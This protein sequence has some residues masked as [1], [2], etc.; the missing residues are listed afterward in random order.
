MDGDVAPLR[1]L[2]EIKE[3]YRAWMMVDEAHA[4]GLYGARRRGLLEEAGVSD[5]VEVQMGTLGKALGSAGGY[6]A[7]SRL[8]VDYLVN[9]AR[10][11]IFS[12]APAPAAAT[13]ATA[14]IGL[15]QSP[16]G[17]D[18]CVR[19]WSNV[20]AARKMMDS[21]IGANTAGPR[22]RSAIL[23]LILGDERR[24]MTAA[25]QLR[26]LGLFVPAIRYPTVARG[27]ARLRFTL[28]AAHEPEHLQRLQLALQSLSP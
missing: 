20:E 12:T 15:V 26:D 21:L 25:D 13:A 14:A 1:E 19:L 9:K 4:T 5:R 6:I 7:G 11:F 16:Q 17:E 18:R 22:C 8:L 10:S 3:R 28:T 23:P 24:A 2:V 27:A